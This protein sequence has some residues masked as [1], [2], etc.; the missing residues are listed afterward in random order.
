[1]AK[2]VKGKLLASLSLLLLLYSSATASRTGG[3]TQLDKETRCTRLYRVAT[4][5]RD[6]DLSARRRMLFCLPLLV[7]ASSSAALRA[8]I[9]TSGNA[10][11]TLSEGDTV[12]LNGA[13]LLVPL[14]VS[15][16]LIS[17]GSG[18]TIDAQHLSRVF[19]VHGVLSLHR[20]H[21][22]NGNATQGLPPL[23]KYGNLPG[24]QWDPAGATNGY[25]TAWGVAF[26]DREQSGAVGGGVLVRAG[27]Y[28][29]LNESSISGCTAMLGAALYIDGGEAVLV[30][31]SVRSCVA[32]VGGIMLIDGASASVSGGVIHDMVG[33]IGAAFAMLDFYTAGG[34]RAPPAGRGR[35]TLRLTGGELRDCAAVVDR[36]SN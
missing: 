34:S 15:L 10:S 28:A 3:S 14:G 31:T 22:I 7:T 18:A 33:A 17:T 6:G 25:N 26:A 20:I 19:E 2:A 12:E 27:G 36:H 13:P 23:P 8:S 16:Q 21:L 4:S 35:S 9:P 1:M 30:A 5:H 32:Q 24:S 11:F 29:Q